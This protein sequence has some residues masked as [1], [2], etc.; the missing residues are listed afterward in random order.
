[1]MTIAVPNMLCVGVKT[2][3]YAAETFINIARPFLGSLLEKYEMYG[4]RSDKWKQALLRKIPY[5]QL[6]A[7]YGGSEDWKPVPLS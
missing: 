1:M 4:T 7:R 5:D 2:A 6:P 3:N